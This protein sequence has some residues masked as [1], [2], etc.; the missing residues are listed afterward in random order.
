M[1]DIHYLDELLDQMAKKWPENRVV[2]I[3]CHGHSVPAGYFATPFVDTF[4]AYPHILH[5]L[6]KERFPYACVNVIVTA[7]G[8]ENS[9]SGEKRFEKE[10]LNHNP[11]LITIDYSLNDR[12][13]GLEQAKKAWE[14]MI[15]SALK[16]GKKVILLT[17]TWD[18]TYYEKNES[19][20][21]LKAHAR[22]VRMLS[23]KYAV[24]LADSFLRWEKNI[25]EPSDLAA[26]LSHVNHPTKKGHELVAEEI[27][28]YFIA[29]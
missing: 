3:V 6:I 1:T 9:V 11:D 20:E 5:A 19:W 2:N 27:A 24:G 25:E 21:M 15:E 18:N 17:P 22:Q 26:Y 13:I 12:S 29:R 14:G 10:V 23:E 28:K 7:I 4:H 16:A 8:G